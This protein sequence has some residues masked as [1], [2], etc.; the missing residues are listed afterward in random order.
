MVFHKVHKIHANH[1]D[2]HCLARPQNVKNSMCAQIVCWIWP[3]HAPNPFQ[4]EALLCGSDVLFRRHLFR[5][6]YQIYYRIWWCFIK[7]AKSMP[8]IVICIAS[9]GHETWTTQYLH[10][11]CVEIS[12]SMPKTYFQMRR[13]CADLKF[14]SGC[15]FFIKSLEHFMKSDGFS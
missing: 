14:R 2:F 1:R 6:I 11:L 12:P 13:C 4:N 5:K 8:A 7:F 3:T 9:R 10:R 15:T